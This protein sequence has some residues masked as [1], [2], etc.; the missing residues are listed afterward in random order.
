MR[1][2]LGELLMVSEESQAAVEQGS[3]SLGRRGQ[4]GQELE[5]GVK[6]VAPVCSTC[7][8]SLASAECL[9]WGYCSRGFSLRGSASWWLQNM[10]SVV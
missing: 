3:C 7:A 9:I 1:R 2:A 6:V 4:Y 5:G 8:G 10:D